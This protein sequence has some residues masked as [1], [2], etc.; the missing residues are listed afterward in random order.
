MKS[1]VWIASWPRSGNTLTRM[2]LN[3][4]FGIKTRSLHN[5]TGLG[6]SKE[7]L[8]LVGH[9]GQGDIHR[10]GEGTFFIKTH[11]LHRK[12]KA[13]YIVRDGRDAVVSYAKHL[14]NF[15]GET[16]NKELLRRCIL[17]T[18]G[19]WASWGQHVNFWF[20]RKPMEDTAII[21]F[22][23]IAGKPQG[24]SKIVGAL[25]DLGL[26][27]AATFQPKQEIPSFSRLHGLN[28]KFFRSGQSGQWQEYFDNELHDLFWSE[29]GDA[30]DR[31]GYEK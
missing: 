17:G 1:I 3:T 21:K 6:G 4:Q 15:S 14:E 13:I 10:G 29:H 2:I 11:E 28:S 9:N 8:D 7:L 24:P 19:M 18:V 30:M 5:D 23:S 22:E 12:N 26:N 27:H 16:F 25:V 31:A 20:D